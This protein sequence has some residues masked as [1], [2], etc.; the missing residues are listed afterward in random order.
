M[1]CRVY[2]AL[3]LFLLFVFIQQFYTEAVERKAQNWKLIQSLRSERILNGIEQ[4]LDS[5]NMAAGLSQSLWSINSNQS[6]HSRSLSLT[7]S[8]E[9]LLLPEVLTFNFKRANL[10]Q[11]RWSNAVWWYENE[12]PLTSQHTKQWKY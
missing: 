7:A 11:T 12:A 9:S 10:S 5:L 2:N 8:N 1:W 4:H 6:H 3:L